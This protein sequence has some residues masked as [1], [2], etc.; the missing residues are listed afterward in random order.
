[1]QHS[2]VSG[3]KPKSELC[4][5]TDILKWMPKF[6]SWHPPTPVL[7]R[8]KRNRPFQMLARWYCYDTSPWVERTQSGLRSQVVLI[9]CAYLR[10]EW[11]N[12]SKWHTYIRTLH[13]EV[14]GFEPSST[15]EPRT[16]KRISPGQLRLR[17][18]SQLKTKFSSKLAGRWQ[19]QK[20]RPSFLSSCYEIWEHKPECK[21]IQ[22]F[23]QI[24]ALGGGY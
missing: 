18:L 20:G 8:K 13:T 5:M 12:G 17:Q 14:K 1:M 15:G 16:R 23:S 22:M 4:R 24:A 19:R 10:K 21:G 9:L 6:F 3:G 7:S 11:E 2:G